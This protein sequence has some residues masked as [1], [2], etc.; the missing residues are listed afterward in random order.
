MKILV[1]GGGGYI[2]SHLVEMLCHKGNI[3]RVFGRNKDH[4]RDACKGVEYFYGDFGDAQQIT[5][6]L[7]G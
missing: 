5:K 4:C 3:V 2:G 6:L 1:L 7:D